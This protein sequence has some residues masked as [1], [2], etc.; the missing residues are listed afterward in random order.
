MYTLL[1]EKCTPPVRQYPLNPGAVAE[2]DV[3]ERELLT[4]GVIR[5]EKN[6]IT[7]SPYSG[8]KETRVSRCVVAA[9]NKL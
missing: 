6:P 3:I 5:T 1:K 9:C 8:S 7:N 4:L 2:M